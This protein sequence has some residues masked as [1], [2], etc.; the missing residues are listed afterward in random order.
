MSKK[1]THEEYISE[2]AK[3]H[4]NIEVI[5]QYAGSNVK[6]LH[7]C[8]IDNYIWYTQPNILLMGHGCPYCS[9][10][11]IMSNNK[12]IEEVKKINPNIE[13]IGEYVGVRTKILHK[14]LID[15]YEWESTPDHILRGSGC[16]MC[17]NT[18]KKNSEQYKKDVELIDNNI[19]VLEEYI[20][21]KTPILHMCKID[22]CRWYAQ[23]SNIL[24]GSGCPMCKLSRGEKRIAAWLNQNNINFSIQK[25]FNK[26]KDK[27][28][29]PFDFYLND[30]NICI[31][32]DGEQH[33]KPIDYFGGEKKFKQTQRRDSI[34]TKYCFDHNIPLLRIRYDQDI[35]GVLY[36]F[37]SQYNVIS[38]EAAS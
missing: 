5:G 3:I 36:E 23:P 20:N 2:L 34:K 38:R 8:R 30:Y 16:P 1:K 19:E 9:K 28:L 35:V 22:G 27:K 11:A 7:K 13:V 32:Y 26:C 6:I 25:T 31:E 29:L 21:Y 37:L 24:A 4:P 33:Y 17:G 15:G 10:H 14:C 12:Y 18:L